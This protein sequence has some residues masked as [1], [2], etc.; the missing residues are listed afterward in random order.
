ML[1]DG[2]SRAALLGPNRWAATLGERLASDMRKDLAATAGVQRS[3]ERPLRPTS[4]LT[5]RGAFGLRR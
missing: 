3:L 5:A 1:A 4:S 2:D